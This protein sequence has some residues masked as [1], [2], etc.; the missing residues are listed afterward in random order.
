MKI[1]YKYSL[2]LMDSQTLELSVGYEILTVQLQNQ[3]ICVWAIVEP[4][5]VE[6]TVQF[7]IIGTGDKIVDEELKYIGTVQR[8]G[9]VWHI[10][11][12]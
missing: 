5:N 3:D 6:Q 4:K 8:H 2:M 12:K 7:Q 11:Y 1:I 10:F 9:F